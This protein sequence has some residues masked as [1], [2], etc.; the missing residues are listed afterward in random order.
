MLVPVLWPGPWGVVG[1]SLWAPASLP[2]FSLD[3]S[4]C[5]CPFSRHLCLRVVLLN[6]PAQFLICSFIVPGFGI[7]TF[8]SSV[9]SLANILNLAC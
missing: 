5:V 4:F 1:A 9:C 7:S 3:A 8:F 2:S 6:A